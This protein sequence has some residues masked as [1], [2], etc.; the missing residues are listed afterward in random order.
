[1]TDSRRLILN[2][3]VLHSAELEDPRSTVNRWHPLVSVAITAAMAVRADARG[4]AAIARWAALEDEF[5][6][7]A[8]DLP[9]CVPR[10]DVFRRVLM[11]PR[12]DASRACW[13][14]R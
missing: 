4:P 8:P 1:M 5:L 13:A 10:E 2:E 12:P 3:V 11:A 14:E 6:V 7:V 9:D